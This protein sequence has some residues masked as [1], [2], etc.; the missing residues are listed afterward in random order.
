MRKLIILTIVSGLLL[1]I[2]LNANICHAAWL[3]TSGTLDAPIL[4]PEEEVKKILIKSITRV[5]PKYSLRPYANG[6]IENGSDW[7]IV[8]FKLTFMDTTTYSSQGYMVTKRV[9]RDDVTKKMIPSVFKPKSAS[10]F[11]TYISYKFNLDLTK[12]GNHY[13]VS[14]FSGY[15]EY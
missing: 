11:S 13:Y 3:H 7:H 14:E 5:N 8:S 10:D 6:E 4:I 15:K 9:R 12:H 2:I 1:I